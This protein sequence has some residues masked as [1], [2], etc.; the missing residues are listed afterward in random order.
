MQLMGG[1]QVVCASTAILY[2]IGCMSILSGNKSM[3]DHPI[4]KGIH[5]P[6]VSN[7]GLSPPSSPLQALKFHI[8]GSL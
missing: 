8:T 3:G 4:L 5:N 7:H 2:Q 6:N 1:L